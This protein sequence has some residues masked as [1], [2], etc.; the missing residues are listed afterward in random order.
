MHREPLQDRRHSNCV[1]RTCRYGKRGSLRVD[2]RTIHTTESAGL[3][4]SLDTSGSVFIGQSNHS[5]LSIIRLLL[6]HPTKFFY[7]SMSINYH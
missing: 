4:T 1:L 2:G 5:L 3:R 6:V 7:K